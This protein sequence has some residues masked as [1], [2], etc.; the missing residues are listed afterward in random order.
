MIAHCPPLSAQQAQ[1]QILAQIQTQNDPRDRRKE[2]VRG[3]EDRRRASQAGGPGAV[4]PPSPVVVRSGSRQQQQQTRAVPNALLPG[5]ANA[6][7]QITPLSAAAHVDVPV[8]TPVRRMSQQLT[9]QHPYANAGYES[10]TAADEYS[11]TQQQQQQQQYGRASPMVSSVGGAAA[12]A[13]SN[14]R[15]VGGEQGVANGGDYHGQGGEER[16]KNTLWQILTCRCG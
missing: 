14:V 11:A 16:P 13:V 6:P 2:A 15:A 12:A 1:N 8:G 4:V 7:G 10:Y 3:G 5:G 9:P